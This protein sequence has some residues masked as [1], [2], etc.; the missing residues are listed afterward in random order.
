MTDTSTLAP[1]ISDNPTGAS[2]VEWSAIFAGAI[3]ASAII[4]LMTA[5]G[6]AIGLSLVSPYRGPS[7]IIFHIALALWFTWITV[8]SF[9]AG[10]YVTGRMRRPVDGATIHESSCQGWRA[11]ACGLGRRG[12][13]RH[14]A[15]DIVDFIRG[16]HVV[17][18]IRGQRRRRSS[19]VRR[20]FDV[21]GRRVRRGS[22]RL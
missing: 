4:V 22:D 14:I 5:F 12:G 20:F 2:Y 13:H 17:A 19:K 21:V 10:G 9:V 1:R 18:F 6:S 7:P 8:S 15:C 16:Q 11:R 3:V